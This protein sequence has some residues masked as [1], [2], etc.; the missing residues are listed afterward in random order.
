MTKIIDIIFWD[1]TEFFSDG[2]PLFSTFHREQT[3][4]IRLAL[5]SGSLERSHSY[6]CRAHGARRG[7]SCRHFKRI[8]RM[9]R[10]RIGPHTISQFYLLVAETSAILSFQFKLINFSGFKWATRDF[11]RAYVTFTFFI[12]FSS[13]LLVMAD[14][15]A[16][17]RRNQIQ[18]TGKLENCY[19]FF[20]FIST[21]LVECQYFQYLTHY[22]EMSVQTFFNE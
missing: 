12:F 19:D 7:S 1:C 6:P 2:T 11:K 22:L 5:K 9:L 20:I 18:T 15:G 17:K 21:P 13:A 14:D 10:R 4:S 8:P 3:G 16:S